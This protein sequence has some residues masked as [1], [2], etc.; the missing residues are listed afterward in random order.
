MRIL[1][2]PKIGCV[3]TNKKKNAVAA[4]KSLSFLRRREII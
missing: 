3:V 2:A 4:S 1:S